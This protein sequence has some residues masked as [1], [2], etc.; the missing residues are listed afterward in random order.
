[1]KQA[2]THVQDARNARNLTQQ[3]VADLLGITLRSYQRYEHG[4]NTL[5][6]ERAMKLSEILGLSV[7]DV[8]RRN[9]TPDFET[10]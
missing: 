3:Q 7:Y 1:M 9:S 10:A 4:E 2:R 5:R 6:P 8:L